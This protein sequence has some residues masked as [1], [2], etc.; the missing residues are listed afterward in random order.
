MEALLPLVD[1]V[2]WVTDPRS[3]P[4]RSCTTSSSGPSIRVSVARWSL[5]N[6]SDRLTPDEGRRIQRDLQADLASG[7]IRGSEAVV[8]RSS[9]TP[10]GGSTTFARGSPPGRRRSGSCASGSRRRSRP[11]PGISRGRRA[12]ASSAGRPFLD[13]PSRAAATRSATEAVLRVID[14]PGL[15]RQA[16]AA[17]QAAARSRGAGPLGRLTSF[18]YRTS[19]RESGRGRPRS[20]PP[21]LA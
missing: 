8:L 11:T 6:K 5:V 3:T 1:A 13:E 19:G 15:R 4:T 16:V 2:A 7:T 20:L 21:A 17:T 14:L 18:I 9:A 12:A 10:P